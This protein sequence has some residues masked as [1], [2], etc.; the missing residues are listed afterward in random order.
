MSDT[1]EKLGAHEVAAWLRRHPNF[2]QQFPDLA[3]SM[4]VPREEG[5]AA[6]LASYQL[7]VLRDKNR[8]L[9]RRLHELFANAQE[10]E[11]LAVRTHQLTLALLRQGNAADTVRAMAASLAEDFQG[12]LVRIVLFEPVAGLD[13]ADW[14]Q[15]IAG[16]RRAP[17]AVPRRARPTANRSAAA[18]IRTRTRCC[19][20]CAPRTCSPARCCRCRASACWRSAAAIANRFFPGMGTLFLRMMG[21][22]LAVGVAALR[23]LTR[24]RALASP[25][26]R[27]ARVPI[28]RPC[29]TPRGLPAAPGRRA[30]DVGAHARCLSP[31]PRRRCRRGRRRRSH[32]LV[33]AA[34]RTAARVRRRRASPRPVAEKPAAALVGLPQFLSLA[35]APRPHRRQPRRGAPRAQGAAQAAAGARCRTKRRRWSKCRP[36][37]RWA[38]AIAR[39]SNCS[40]PPACACRSCA[41]CAG[42]TSISPT[43]W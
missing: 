8:E 43:A 22:A 18:C 15:V 30:A 39:C 29:P 13:D 17:G 5:P 21:E 26:A 7:D 27:S 9:S 10:N 41:R 40:I 11:R 3:I 19:T 36:T 2:L 38:C 34:H 20:A 23:W 4:V 24:A 33:D 25:T 16:R 1:T 12:D 37:C 6:S 32:D 42:A 14:L 31:R 28:E 35:A